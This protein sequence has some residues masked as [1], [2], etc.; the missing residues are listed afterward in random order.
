MSLRDQMLKAGL[1]SGDEVKKV[2]TGKRK[3][4]HRQ[5]KDR[6]LAAEA[7]AEQQQRQLEVEQARAA[8]IERQR[9]LER[10][11]AAERERREQV[12][13]AWQLIEA[14][15]LNETQADIHYHF[16]V[17]EGQHIRYVNVTLAQQSALASG[18]LGIACQ[19]DD[20][21]DL[22]LLPREAIDRL[23]SFVPQQVVLLHPLGRAEQDSK[24]SDPAAES[25]M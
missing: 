2:E 19:H 13:R 21:H 25:P 16:L 22:A 18:Q 5:R 9:A 17:D 12:L 8:D 23:S 14:Q 6:R 15:R 20:P 1:V 10:E 3:K 11:R 24:D 7:A 4:Q